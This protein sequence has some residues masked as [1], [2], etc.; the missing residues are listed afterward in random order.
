MVALRCK[1]LVSG[2]SVFEFVG[3]SPAKGMDYFFS[4]VVSCQEE[5]TATS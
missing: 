4:S 2:Q 1:E 5:I 3:S